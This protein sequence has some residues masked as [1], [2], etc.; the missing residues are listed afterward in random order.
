MINNAKFV[1][2][3]QY[4]G[5]HAF[6][7]GILIQGGENYALA[8]RAKNGRIILE[9]HPRRGI[10]AAKLKSPALGRIVSVFDAVLSSAVFLKRAFALNKSISVVRMFRNHGAEHK[11]IH[12]YENGEPLELK[13]VKQQP[14]YHPRCGTSAAANILV[15]ESLL[16]LI[17][18]SR[19]RQAY[20][21]ALDIIVMLTAVCAGFETSRYAAEKGGRLA[22]ILAFP[23]R[24]MQKATALEPTDS[25]LECAI[26]AA[27]GVMKSEV[28]K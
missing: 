20:H 26:A 2:S 28:I 25:M 16:C 13:N 1:R 14:T 17:I 23:G 22:R 9:K 4:I 19:I 6:S 24:I 10:S 18:P 7:N 12:C 21:G 5:G 15:I 11:V 3:P 27:K 8:V